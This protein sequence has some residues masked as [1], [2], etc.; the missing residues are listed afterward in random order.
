MPTS[1]TAAEDRLVRSLVE[2][3]LEAGLSHS[4]AVNL[5]IAVFKELDILVADGDVTGLNCLSSTAV[6]EIRQYTRAI[7]RSGSTF[8][9]FEIAVRAVKAREMVAAELV[10][11]RESLR[12]GRRS[13]KRRGELRHKRLERAGKLP[14]LPAKVQVPSLEVDAEGWDEVEPSEPIDIDLLSVGI[15][16]VRYRW[17][18]E[19]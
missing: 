7:L 11:M 5:A 9:A 3:G 18:V 16:D 8:S 13:Q 12:W 17:E 15:D 10:K 19:E 6:R 4:D 1:S 14:G 2:C